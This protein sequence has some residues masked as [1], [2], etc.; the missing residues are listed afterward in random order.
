MEEGG[1]VPQ[2]MSDEQHSIGGD[3]SSG[4]ARLVKISLQLIYGWLAKGLP[5]GTDYLAGGLVSISRRSAYDFRMARL[6]PQTQMETGQLRW[7]RGFCVMNTSIRPLFSSLLF[8]SR[9]DRLARQ[10]KAGV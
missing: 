6:P 10:T 7:I 1:E 8:L 9:S 2:L 5:V 3:I 4:L